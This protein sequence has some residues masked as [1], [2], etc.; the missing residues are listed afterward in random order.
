MIYSFHFIGDRKRTP[1]DKFLNE[2][3]RKLT[4]FK[5]HTDNT[6]NLYEKEYKELKSENEEQYKRSLFEANAEFDKLVAGGGYNTDE[7]LQFAWHASGGSSVDSYFQDEDEALFD[8]FNTMKDYFYKSSLSSL[9][10]LLESELRALCGILKLSYNKKISLQNLNDKDYL[11]AIVTYLELV[12]EVETY[13]LESYIT[14]FR[15]LQFIRNKIMHN[16][17]VIP[18][19]E[20]EKFSKE[21]IYNESAIC[22][23][24]S[25]TVFIKNVQL[26]ENNLQLIRDFFYELRWVLDKKSDYSIL[27]HNLTFFFEQFSKKIKVSILEVSQQRN[28]IKCHLVYDSSELQL[29]FFC[30]ISFLKAKVKDTVIISQLT[31]EIL[32]E[33]LSNLEWPSGIIHD[34]ILTG[35]LSDKNCKVKFMLYE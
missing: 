3:D 30:N 31:N 16:G 27:T 1:L 28:F 24:E 22:L 4:L 34:N 29:L 32:I 10:A 14:K 13:T 9:Y 15:R 25:S 11:T 20:R 33:L 7:D 6:N 19:E 17:G 8:R 23:I 26:I 18:E 2:I 35:Y 12:I 5:K 21:I